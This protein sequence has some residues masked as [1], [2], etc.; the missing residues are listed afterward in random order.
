MAAGRMEAIR[1]GARSQVLLIDGFRTKAARRRKSTVGRA[2]RTRF[3][4]IF[5]EGAR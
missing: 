2:W 4:L 5:D 1:N 3:E